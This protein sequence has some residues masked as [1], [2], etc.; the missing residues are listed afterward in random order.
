MTTPLQR[1]VDRMHRDQ[2]MRIAIAAM[3]RLFYGDDPL[4]PVKPWSS[5]D[6]LKTRTK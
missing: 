5:L 2:D 4:P 3:D 6:L 1:L